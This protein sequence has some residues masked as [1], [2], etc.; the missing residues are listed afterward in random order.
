[1]KFKKLQ[2]TALSLAALAVPTFGESLYDLA[3]L[4]EDDTGSAVSYSVGLNVGYDDN[5]N[6]TDGNEDSSLYIEPHITASIGNSTPQTTWQLYGRLGVLF[7]LDDIEVA[8]GTDREYFSSSRIGFNLTHRFNERLRF[9]S[10]SFVAYEIEPDY[11][12]SFAQTRAN[13]EYFYISSDN[14]FGYR[15]TQRFATFTGARISYLNFSGTEDSDRLTIEPY[16]QGRY[17]LTPQTV[18]T[19]GYRYRDSSADGNGTD[20]TS[21]IITGGI[22]HRF[23]PNTIGTLRAGVQIRDFDGGGDSTS[24]YVEAALRSRVNN[25]FSIRS[26]VR[27]SQEDFNII[28]DFEDQDTLR[29]GVTGTYAVSP[30]LSLSGGVNYVYTEYSD[31]ASGL[32]DADRQLLHFNAGATLKLTDNV[33]LNARYNYTTTDI[34]PGVGIDFDRNR[35]SVGITAD[36]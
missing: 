4:G 36:F 35:V 5:V 2:I 3:S 13:E 19:A 17:Q 32:S 27:Y 22:E 28:G 18:L 24:P 29:L 8:G 30:R 23:S 9:T 16:I 33:A 31:S 12:N 10:R 1:M 20:T 21:H 6:A 34:D 14:S 26:F 11:D 25:Q 7:Y 15:W